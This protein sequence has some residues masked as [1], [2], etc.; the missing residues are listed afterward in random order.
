MFVMNTKC[1]AYS[2]KSGVSFLSNNRKGI[3]QLYQDFHLVSN[4]LSFFQMYDVQLL[5]H[6][7]R[8]TAV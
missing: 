1:E 5:S 2:H 4:L 7:G 3:A 8:E 6:L